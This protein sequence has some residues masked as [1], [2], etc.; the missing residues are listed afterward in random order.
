MNKKTT[1]QKKIQGTLKKSRE[2]SELNY[3]PLT[4][5]PA[6]SFDLNVDGQTY[7]DQFCGILISNSTLTAADVPG[8]T[9]AARWFELYKEADANV[10]ARGSV[11]VT[12][13]GYTQQTGYFTVMEKSEDRLIKF[14]AL[15]GM[16][17]TARTKINIPKPK[18]K[19]PFDDV[20]QL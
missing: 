12:S 6:P 7:F 1:E 20:M 8:I 15:Y 18:E 3:E 17:L 10:L 9:R 14:E 19:N 2:K 16:N 11:Q 4:S 13:T 5:I